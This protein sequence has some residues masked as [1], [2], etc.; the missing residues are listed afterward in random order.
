MV[1]ISLIP[2]ARMDVSAAV[3]ACSDAFGNCSR[4][5]KKSDGETKRFHDFDTKESD[6]SGLLVEQVKFASRV[7]CCQFQDGGGVSR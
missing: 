7:P 3:S 1:V 6:L 2:D 5:Y 4:K